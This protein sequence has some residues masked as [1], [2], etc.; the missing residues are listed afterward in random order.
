VPLCSPA[1]I[2]GS[3]SALKLVCRS[4]IGTSRRGGPS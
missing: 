4:K 2:T 3:S 1:N